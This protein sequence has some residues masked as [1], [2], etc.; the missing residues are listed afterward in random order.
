MKKD[1]GSLKKKY[2]QLYYDLREILNKEDPIG[3]IEIGAP[4]DE[5]DSEISTILPK[6][7]PCISVE[8][9]QAMIH[10]EFVKWFD[11]NIA[12]PLERYRRIAKQV[13]ALKEKI[14]T[15]S[16]NKV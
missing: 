12:G 6:L 5:Y 8:E 9:L 4:D 15:T 16:S 3:L 11:E 2:G 13:K 7:K 10:A 14:G 1:I